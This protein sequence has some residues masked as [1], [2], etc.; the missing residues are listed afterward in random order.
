M[1][2][3]NYKDMIL[4]LIHEEV[5]EA[6]K[7]MRVNDHTLGTMFVFN[8]YKNIAGKIYD[9]ERKKLNPPPT[10]SKEVFR[11]D[12]KFLALAQTRTGAKKL[13]RQTVLE[14]VAELLYK[15]QV[16]EKVKKPS[17]DRAFED[18]AD[19][20]EACTIHSNDSA[21][22]TVVEGRQGDD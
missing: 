21:V 16:A 8:K 18:A 5:E 20:V 19:I 14:H 6:Y 3:V 12:G 7:G 2:S 4:D 13:D 22:I 9:N 17:R 10:K 15:L 11:D 1:T